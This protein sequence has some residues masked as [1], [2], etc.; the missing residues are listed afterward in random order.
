M[1]RKLGTTLDSSKSIPNTDTEI[2]HFAQLQ[3][4]VVYFRASS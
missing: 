4:S 2:S 3:Q 1:D